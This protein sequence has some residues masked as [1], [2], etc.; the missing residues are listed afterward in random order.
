MSVLLLALLLTAHPGAPAPRGEEGVGALGVHLVL[1]GE[2][3]IELA[4]DYDLGFNAMAA[5]NPQLDPFVPKA[6]AVALLPTA[7]ILPRAAAPGTIVVNL[8]EMRLYLV[9]AAGAPASWAT[10]L[11]TRRYV[12]TL[13]A[14]LS[15]SQ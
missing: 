12:M 10:S 9:R 13:S 14:I 5:A 15:A 1:P 7:W 6:G 3:L 11:T 2:S 8:S 4:E